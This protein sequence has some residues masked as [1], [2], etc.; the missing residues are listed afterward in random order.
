MFARSHR[1]PSGA[2]CCAA[3]LVGTKQIAKVLHTPQRGIRRATVAHPLGPRST[4]LQAL[5]D[6]CWHDSEV[7]SSQ[8]KLVHHHDYDIRRRNM[9]DWKL[10]Q[11]I[12]QSIER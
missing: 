2:T 5:T 6:N 8:G 9:R 1:T 10:Q 12:M 11:A 7:L 3:E 4:R